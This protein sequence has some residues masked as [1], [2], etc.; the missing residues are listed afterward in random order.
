MVADN[1]V[2]VVVR[3]G[4]MVITPLRGVRGKSNLRRLV[5]RIPKDYKPQETDWGKPAGKE[6]W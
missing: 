2:D 1:T 3:K 6:V 4:A 5:K